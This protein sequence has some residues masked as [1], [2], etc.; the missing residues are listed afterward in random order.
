MPAESDLALRVF[1]GSRAR[2]LTLGVLASAEAPLTGYRVASVTGLPRSKVYPELRKAVKAGIVERTDIGFSL[3][4]PD[5]R[6]MLRARIRVTWDSYWDRPDRS[7]SLAVRRELDRI[8]RARKRVP[9][10]NPKNNIP[11]SAIR[12]LTRDPDKNRALRRLALKPS[13]RKDP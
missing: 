4:D 5:I 8:R 12:E 3:V 10:F 6:T 11:E 7:T 13:E 2:L 1:C 9:L